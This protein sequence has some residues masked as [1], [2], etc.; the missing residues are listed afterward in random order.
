MRVSWFYLRGEEEDGDCWCSLLT[1][2]CRRAV[3]CYGQY[4]QQSPYWKTG[5]M[6]ITWAINR[7]AKRGGMMITTHDLEDE[8]EEGDCWCSLLTW[9]CRRAVGCYGQYSQQSPYWK[10]G[11]MQITWAINRDAKRGGMMITAHDLED[12]R[13]RP[14]SIRR[15]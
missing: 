10:T 15:K 6:Q 9:I 12:E 5:V 3:G 1:W 2:I 11:V 14:E 7:D 4:S 13:R 8:R